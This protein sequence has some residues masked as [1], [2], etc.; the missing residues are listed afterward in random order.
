MRRIPFAAA[1]LASA[2]AP[3][4]LRAQATQQQQPS[5][6]A[7]ADAPARTPGGA[8]FTAPAGWTSRQGA[9]FVE[10]TPPEGDFRIA[11]VDVASAAD[12]K[13]A[14]AAAWAAWA[15][16]KAK[17]PKLV[18]A[19]AARNGWEERWAI[20]YETSPNEKRIMAAGAMRAGGSGPS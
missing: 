14:T 6:K 7:A 15:P 19:S 16:A 3:A 20:D 2:S 8:T 17:E 11:I 4:T 1:L 18:S 9:G 12:A 13:A 5:A 10:L